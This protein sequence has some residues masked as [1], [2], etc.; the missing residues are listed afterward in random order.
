MIFDLHNIVPSVGQVNALRSD[1]RYGIIAGEDLKLS[2][3]F[4]WEGDIAEP[5][6]EK[7]GEVARIW[8]YMHSQHGVE[9]KTGELL[10]YMSWSQND[11]PEAWEFE[12]DDRIKTKQ[13]NGNPFVEMFRWV[14][15][16][17]FHL[18]LHNF[19]KK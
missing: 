15:L 12:R 17:R 10:M 18:F 8:L 19:S 5:P 16:I 14:Y 11:P 4:E 1:K 13:G 2:C 6:A 9:L 3:D 7:R